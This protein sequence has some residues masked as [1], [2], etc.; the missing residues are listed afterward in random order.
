MSEVAV[1]QQQKVCKLQ[2]VYLEMIYNN[3][4]K[5][6]VVSG[7]FL[8]ITKRKEQTFV[9]LHGLKDAV[10]V[11]NTA[12]YN[13]MSIEVLEDEYKNMTYLT[14]ERQDQDM[15]NQMLE[16]LYN[17]LVENSFGLENDS[18]II[19][20]AKYANVPN[21]Y[22]DGKPIITTVIDK[23]GSKTINNG[24]HKP[25][26]TRYNSEINGTTYNKTV[27]KADPEPSLLGRA[28]TKK[29][30]KQDIDLLREKID[31][32]KAGSY[33]ANLPETLGGTPSSYESRKFDEDYDVYGGM[34]GQGY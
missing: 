12:Y 15:A 17:T 3:E 1:D 29:P 31:S 21:D 26:V 8:G 33:V 20:I 6:D 32:I 27:V 30:S 28:K 23:T 34:Y 11:L 24:S 10:A 25:P 14:S 4:T 22:K 19:D 9:L 13:V 2:Y 16:E 5:Y 18:K 7:L